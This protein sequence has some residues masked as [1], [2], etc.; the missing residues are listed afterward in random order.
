MKRLLIFS[1]LTISLFQ[2]L[3]TNCAEQKEKAEASVKVIPYAE[4]IQNLISVTDNKNLKAAYAWFLEYATKID[5]QELNKILCNLFCNLS[6]SDASIIQLNKFPVLKAI[7]L[8]NPSARTTGETTETFTKVLNEL[9]SAERAMVETFVKLEEGVQDSVGEIFE[10]L[11]EYLFKLGYLNISKQQGE[12]VLL[13]KR[14]QKRDQEARE[15]EWKMIQEQMEFD[16]RR[17]DLECKKIAEAK[18]AEKKS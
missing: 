8:S 10:T 17:L 13:L 9:S 14:M 16:L 3:S 6:K 5:Q 12:L 18:K 11:P 2:T 1:I 4:I 7:R 15:L